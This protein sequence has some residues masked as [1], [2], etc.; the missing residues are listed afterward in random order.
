VARRVKTKEV[1]VSA[2]VPAG[3]AMFLMVK[4]S[5]FGNRTTAE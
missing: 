5:S 3:R 2:K 4:Y 1:A